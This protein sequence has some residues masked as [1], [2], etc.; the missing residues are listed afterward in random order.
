MGLA[1]SYPS[2][3]SRKCTLYYRTNLTSGGWTN[4]PPRTDLPGS[5]GVDTL[6]DPS[7]TGEQRFYRIGVR[8]P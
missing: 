4:M 8:L 1:V 6:T 7:P 2:S 3:A 5:G